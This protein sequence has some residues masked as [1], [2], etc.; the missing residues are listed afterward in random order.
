LLTGGA[1]PTAL[2]EDAN[3][4]GIGLAS[5]ALVN[6]SASLVFAKMSISASMATLGVD[7]FT[8]DV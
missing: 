3:D 4:E 5:V 7:C 8:L 1:I 2:L 6:G